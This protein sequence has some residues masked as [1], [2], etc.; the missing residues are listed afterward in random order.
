MPRFESFEQIEIINSFPSFLC[1]FIHPKASV[2]VA[3]MCYTLAIS[4]L[5]CLM[6]P[7]YFFHC[8]T[9]GNMAIFN[10]CDQHSSVI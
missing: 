9:S 8:L 7:K 10:K 2:L 3:L 1:S 5:R 4:L 6:N